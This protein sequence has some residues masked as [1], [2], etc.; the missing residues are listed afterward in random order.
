MSLRVTKQSLFKIRYNT[1]LI[2]T[3]NRFIFSTFKRT[4]LKTKILGLSE[5]V[6]LSLYLIHNN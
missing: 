5:K 6:D 3:S 1:T 4:L 2:K